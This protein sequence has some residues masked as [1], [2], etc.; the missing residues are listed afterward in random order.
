MNATK[1]KNRQDATKEAGI[2][3]QLNN[4]IYALASHLY[5]YVDILRQSTVRPNTK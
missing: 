4:S 3:N 1:G 5:Q 2:L